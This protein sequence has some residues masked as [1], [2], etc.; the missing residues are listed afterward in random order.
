MNN[1]KKATGWAGKVFKVDRCIQVSVIT[2]CVLKK[3]IN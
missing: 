1:K 2:T 3:K